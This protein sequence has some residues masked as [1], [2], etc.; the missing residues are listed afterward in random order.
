MWYERNRWKEGTILK[1][2]PTR[3][4][5]YYEYGYDSNGKLLVARNHVSSEPDRCWYYE[6][7]Y[8]YIQAI[9]ESAHFH[10]NPEKEPI[11]LSRS[12]YQGNQITLW[13]SCAKRGIMRER[14]RWNK[15]HIVFIDVDYARINN[16]DFIEP[17][18]WQQVDASYTNRGTLDKV[19]IHWQKRPDQPK[20]LAETA[21]RRLE[22]AR[23]FGSLLSLA[24]Q[25]LYDAI[26]QTI[27]KLELQEDVY[28][29]AVTWSPGQYQSL[30][31]HLGIGFNRDKEIWIAEHGKE[32]ARWYIW[33]PA[34]FSFQ[35]IDQT[36][37]NDKELIEVCELLNQ[38][39][40]RHNKWHQTSKMLSEVAKMLN[41]TNWSGIL[42]TTDNFIAYATNYELS[43]WQ[44]YIRLSITKETFAHLKK[45]GL[46]I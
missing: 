42:H 4:N 1:V 17:T 2:P 41:E 20:E 8:I 29:I 32:E 36:V 45:E 37:F 39:C 35:I 18:P 33:N 30:P 3:P 34:E 40:G 23:T 25:K 27:T 31:P 12:I 13:E 10:Y 21:Y 44:K 7:F 14:Y 5:G 16:S 46:L 6:T 22:K 15:N 43:D 24:K 19:V 38:E 9:I 26:V 11:N 28:C